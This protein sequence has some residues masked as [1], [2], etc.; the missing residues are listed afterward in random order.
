[1]LHTDISKFNIPT[2]PH[3]TRGLT[4]SR[5]SDSQAPEIHTGGQ[6]QCLNRED[7]NMAG[8]GETKVTE[9]KRVV[10]TAGEMA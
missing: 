7:E 1:M 8:E 2:S 5:V 9:R 6:T 4:L 3:D 10:A